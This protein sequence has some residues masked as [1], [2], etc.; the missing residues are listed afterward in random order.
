MQQIP[1]KT[2]IDEFDKIIKFIRDNIN[3]FSEKD[4][5]AVKA[6][7]RTLQTKNLSFYTAKLRQFKFDESGFK[8][9]VINLIDEFLKTYEPL[10][11]TF[12]REFISQLNDFKQNINNIQDLTLTSEKERVDNIQQKFSAMKKP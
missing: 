2:I 6:L 8:D 1:K 9:D 7:G 12:N 10:H 4:K 3:N 11:D 5:E